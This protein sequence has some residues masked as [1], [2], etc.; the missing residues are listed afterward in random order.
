MKSLIISLS[1]LAALSL[2]SIPLALAAGQTPGKPST[3]PQ[4]PSAAVIDTVPP[5]TVIETPFTIQ[6]GTMALPGTLT[7]PAKSK[8]RIPVAL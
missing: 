7:L 6:S 1:G 8:H 3:P 5:K 2:S 4:A